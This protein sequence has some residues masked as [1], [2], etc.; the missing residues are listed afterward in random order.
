LLAHKTDIIIK[1]LHFK[2]LCQL[3][4][5]SQSVEHNQQQHNFAQNK[6]CE[7]L[8][9]RDVWGKSFVQTV[10]ILVTHNRVCYLIG[11]FVVLSEV[12]VFGAAVWRHLLALLSLVVTEAAWGWRRGAAEARWNWYRQIY[13][14]VLN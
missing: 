4:N 14:A 5:S 6:F 9:N 10:S 2:L 11:V 3:K 8:Q 12:G 1:K 13:L 7:T